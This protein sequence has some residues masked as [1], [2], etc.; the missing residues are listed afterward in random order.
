MRHKRILK[1]LILFVCM[2]PCL[3]MA[4]IYQYTDEQGNVQFT[5]KPIPGAGKVKLK[6]LQTYQPATT[7]P[8]TV[9]TKPDTQAPKPTATTNYQSIK[10]IQ[11]SDGETFR[12]DQGIVPVALALNPPLDITNGH[13][14]QVQLDGKPMGEP[15]AATGFTL[16]NI[17]RGTHTVVVDIIDGQG[18]VVGSSNQVAFYMHRTIAPVPSIPLNTPATPLRRPALP[19]RTPALPLKPPVS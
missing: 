4:E 12:D 5:D 14:I 7:P 8:P 16:F 1:V 2:L 11:P 9:N 17:N 3:C 18:R 6:Q 13:K 10:I 19:L 15:Q